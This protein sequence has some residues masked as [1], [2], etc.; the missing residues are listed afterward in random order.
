M[1]F[2]ELCRTRYSVRRFAQRTVET[3]KLERILEA[4]RLAP[5]AKN[6]QSHRIFVLKSNEA[7][8]KVRAA[9]RMAFDAPVVLMVCY[10]E[11]QSYKNTA[12]THFARYDGGEVDAAI[13]VSAMM[14]EATEMG[15]GT[16]WARGFDSQRLYDAFPEIA[17]L[18]LVCLLDIGYPAEGSTPSD[19]HSDRKPLSQTV[20]EL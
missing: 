9:T 1:D 7:L 13:V 16:L 4:G 6:C 15:L 2:L 11:E 20:T 17:H 14:M 10:D 18:H 12:D 3:D 5:T 8:A 19:R